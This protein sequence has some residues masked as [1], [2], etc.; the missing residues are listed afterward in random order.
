MFQFEHTKLPNSKWKRTRNWNESRENINHLCWR[1]GDRRYCILCTVIVPICSSYSFHYYLCV[2]FHANPIGHGYYGHGQKPKIIPFQ[3]NIDPFIHSL[4]V[5]WVALWMSFRNGFISFE[6]SKDKIIERAI[7]FGLL[8]CLFVCLLEM[9]C[10]M[11]RYDH[12]R[13]TRTLYFSHHMACAVHD[14]WLTNVHISE[15]TA[16]CLII[17]IVF[18]IR[19]WFFSVCDALCISNQPE[20]TLK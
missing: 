4:P 20:L 15:H 12:L 18:V 9:S 11:L 19:T 2:H 7:R 13:I 14:L 8:V 16:L 3:V 6:F 10:F 5:H 17:I 1:N